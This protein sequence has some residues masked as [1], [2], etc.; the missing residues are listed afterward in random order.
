MGVPEWG[1]CPEAI[2]AG[3]MGVP[4]PSKGDWVCRERAGHESGL[5]TGAPAL[6]HPLVQRAERRFLWG[7]KDEALDLLGQNDH[8]GRSAAGWL[9]IM[10]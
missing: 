2:V 7:D 9:D 6:L 10:E 3:A 8:L 1:A 4:E 5:R